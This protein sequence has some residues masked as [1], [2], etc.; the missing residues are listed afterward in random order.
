MT[1][2]KYGQASEI[3]FGTDGKGAGAGL[4][5]VNSFSVEQSYATELFLK[6]ATG[7]T[8]GLIQGDSRTTGTISGYGTGS[9][10]TLG[11]SFNNDLGVGDAQCAVSAVRSSGSNEDF[12][13][14][15]LS[16][17]AFEGVDTTCDANAKHDIEPLK[18]A[19]RN[20]DL[21]ELAYLVSEL[22]R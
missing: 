4:T 13:T 1:I 22:Q 12:T 18:N 17:N 14:Y 7:K 2:T 3:D 9:T 20:D 11:A 10:V 5:I 6:D 16:F 19:P 15:E 21:S 8:T